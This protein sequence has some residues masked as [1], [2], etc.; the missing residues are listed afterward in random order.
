[1]NRS[2][3]EVEM[4][5]DS[6][7]LIWFNNMDWVVACIYVASRPHCLGQVAS[8]PVVPWYE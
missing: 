6:F 4:T 7:G 1:M 8:S 2:P 5:K 3:D